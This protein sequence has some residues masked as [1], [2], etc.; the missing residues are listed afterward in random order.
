LETSRKNLVEGKSFILTI[1][2]DKVSS[3]NKPRRANIRKILSLEEAAN[4]EYNSVY[5]E[6]DTTNN[7]HKLY[8]NIKEKGVSKIKI[9]I[10]D[11]KKNYLF[12]LK[13]KRKF[14][15]QTLK[16]LNKEQYIKKIRV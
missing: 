1:I 3:E 9:F 16:N 6:I 11:K 8:E 10:E 12:E 15:Y 7:L 2:R 4:K 13:Q 5:I 14:D